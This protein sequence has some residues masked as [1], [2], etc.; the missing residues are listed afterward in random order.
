[1]TRA[2]AIQVLA[3]ASMAACSSDGGDDEGPGIEHAYGPLELCGF[4]SGFPFDIEHHCKRPQL[5]KSSSVQFTTWSALPAY[6]AP[7]FTDTISATSTFN[8]RPAT[9]PI[10]DVRPGMLS[11]GVSPQYG[12]DGSLVYLP[13]PYGHPDFYFFKGDATAMTSLAAAGQP[14]IDLAAKSSAPYVKDQS[15]VNSTFGTSSSFS[16]DG[17]DVALVGNPYQLGWN[18]QSFGVWNHRTLD[19][20]PEGSAFSFGAPTPASS[21]PSSGTAVFSGKLAGL[22]KDPGASGHLATANVT[23]D[24]DFGA[25]SLTVSFSSSGT[26]LTRSADE[27]GFGAPH[28]DLSGTLTYSAAVNRFTGT[29]TNAGGTMSGSST[30]QFYGPG[31]E[32]LGGVVKLSAPSSPEQFLGAYGARR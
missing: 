3:V 14:G 21:V 22:Y 2:L 13:D 5:A 25:P 23:L 31:A 9:P 27:P 28:L 26:V 4:A 18:Y 24:V 11:G 6:T 10:W 7:L 30:G 8:L 32:E 16:I 12:P 20:A 1:M 29:V 15:L 19:T 17:F